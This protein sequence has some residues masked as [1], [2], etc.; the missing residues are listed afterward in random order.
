MLV[1]DLALA[2]EPSG[3]R[4]VRRFRRFRGGPRF[5]PGRVAARLF[6]ALARRVVAARSVF[7]LWGGE[8]SL[9]GAFS[10]SGAESCRCAERCPQI[11]RSTLRAARRLR[12]NDAERSAIMPQTTET[13]RDHA[14]ARELS[15]IMPQDGNSPRSPARRS[16]NRRNRARLAPQ[17]PHRVTLGDRASRPGPGRGGVPSGHESRGSLPGAGDLP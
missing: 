17:D 14:P 9:R 2:S 6:P 16:R 15:A 10:G 12:G 13:L 7:R 4:V 11:E 8:L 5:W 3:G 1:L